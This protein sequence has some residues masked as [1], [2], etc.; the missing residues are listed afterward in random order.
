MKNR[1]DLLLINPLAKKRVYQDLSKDYSAIEPPFWAALTAGFIRNKGYNV[2][3]LDA[4]AENLSIEETVK[5]INYLNPK[6]TNIVVFGQQPSASTQ[7]MTGVGDLCK[8]TK[9]L[10][11]N[12]KII[13]TG[14]HPSA[15]P[16]K[17]LK[18]EACDFI[19]KGEGFYTLKEL[20][21]GKKLNKIPGLWYK[22]NGIK[23]KI[24]SG[25]NASLV[26][27]LDS[28]LSEVAWD[29]LPMEKYRAH[30]WHCF[31]DINKR[32]PYGALYTSLGC[33]YDCDFCCI[34][35]TFD[36]PSY[37]M[38][39]PEWTLK[40]IGILAEKYNIKKIKIID[41]LF[42]LNNKH[43][44][45]ICDRIADRNYD[46]DMWAYARIDTIKENDLDKIRK[47]GIK[48]LAL[49]IESANKNVRTESSSKRFINE[50]IFESVE[51]IR[52]HDIKIGANYIFGLPEDDLET[53]QQTL[54]LA[55]ELNGEWDNFYSAMAYPG[56]KL[57]D[58]ALKQGFKLPDSWVGYSQHSYECQP[59]PT[60]KISAKEVL[61]FRDYAFNT[62]FTNPKYLNMIEDKFGISARRHIEKMIKIKLK[63][64]LLENK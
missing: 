36:K 30:N 56:S 46:L 55:I 47:A 48:W 22:E 41:E 50:K 31:D 58:R 5:R 60:N 21:D 26:K 25:P 12:L 39:S 6:L 51:K 28:E 9:D 27:N 61:K 2:D 35:A 16:K 20:L 57:Y 34:N 64:K 37:R 19:G 43:V 1:L 10:N 23:N 32:E 14:T 54:D 29:L 59:L 13:L 45:G 63:R 8:Q 7:L 17:T 44:E 42:V 24:N 4:N 52:N 18:E 15:L 33:P 3:I 11:K 40:Q 49:G 38:W 62:F 53:M